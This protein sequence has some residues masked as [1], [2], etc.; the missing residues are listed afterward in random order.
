[1]LPVARVV[2]AEA[3]LIGGLS[4]GRRRKAIGK[5]RDGCTAGRG[6]GG[7][8]AAALQRIG[9]EPVERKPHRQVCGQ[10]VVDHLDGEPVIGS[11]GIGSERV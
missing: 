8:R 10:S 11:R 5:K 4:N 9:L 6:G 2:A 1:M 7:V 3:G